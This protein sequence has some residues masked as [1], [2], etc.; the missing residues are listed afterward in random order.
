MPLPAAWRVLWGVAFVATCFTYSR[1]GTVDAASSTEPISNE[2]FDDL[3]ELA[4][5]V[6][7]SYCVGGLGVQQPFECANRCKDFPDFELITTFNT[8]PLLADSCGYVALSNPP[9]AP[10]IIVAFR[11]TYSVSNAIVDLSTVP[12]EFVPYPDTDDGTAADSEHSSRCSNCTVHSGFYT[13]WR[14]TRTVIL[15][16]IT[17][18]IEDN[19]GYRLTLV[20]HSLGGAVAALA[21]LEF[22]ARGWNPIVTTFGEPR[23]GN[24]ALVDYIDKRFNLESPSNRSSYRRVTHYDDPVPLL[25]LTEW[26][27]RSHGGEVFITKSALPP[28]VEDIVLCSG[29]EDSN[30]VAGSDD[31]LLVQ[32]NLESSTSGSDSNLELR[33][34]HAQGLSLP[35]R[36][37][38]WE[39]FF[40][41]RDYFWRIGLCVPGGDPFDRDGIFHPSL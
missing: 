35:L 8:G 38:L 4:R 2:L 10:R 13:A 25:P 12:Q 21:S 16:Y 26:G 31:S 37:R 41:H 7:V 24:S 19:P 3:E 5:I 17:K 30:C 27:Y 36:Y 33:D 1:G 20:G 32:E 23:V 28:S 15:P 22:S 34:I 6:D 14:N 39:L 40:S 11:G 9:S 18:A 29:D